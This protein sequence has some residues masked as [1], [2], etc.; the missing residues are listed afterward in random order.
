MQTN[1]GLMLQI[2]FTFNCVVIVRIILILRALSTF[3]RFIVNTPLSPTC[4]IKTSSSD[5]ADDES[6]IACNTRRRNSS[7]YHYS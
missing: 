3:G 2:Q 5:T 4:D 1:T 7:G 6:D